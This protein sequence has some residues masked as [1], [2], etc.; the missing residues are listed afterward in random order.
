[1]ERH[2]VPRSS[3]VKPHRAS[4][5]SSSRWPLGDPRKSRK[6]TR[7]MQR[8][9]ASISNSEINFIDERMGILAA[10]LVEISSPPEKNGVRAAVKRNLLGS[11]TIPSPTSSSVKHPITSQVDRWKRSQ[12]RKSS[13][14][15]PPGKPNDLARICRNDGYLA[16]P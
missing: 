11:A 3:A 6:E 1:M 10:I 16:E 5:L 4:S 2:V 15:F 14:A 12:P 8:R 13:F 7:E 9:D